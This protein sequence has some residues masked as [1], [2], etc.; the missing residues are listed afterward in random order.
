MV[1]CSPK[2][3]SFNL[4]ILF[5][6]FFAIGAMRDLKKR[7]AKQSITSNDKPAFQFVQI[8]LGSRSSFQNLNFPS[9]F[10]PLISQESA[11]N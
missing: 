10:F 5:A 8:F 3:D 2:Y 9:A 6:Y 11:F 4:L 1:N 7:E